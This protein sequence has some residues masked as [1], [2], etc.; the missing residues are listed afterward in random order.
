MSKKTI[1]EINNLKKFFVNKSIVNKAVDDVSF[2]LKE[3]EIVGLI[4]ES[5][6]GKTTIGRSLLRLYDDY[7]GF[8]RLDGK[9]IS[10]KKISRKTNK[11]MRKNIQMIFQDP[12]AH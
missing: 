7:N 1:L 10:G 4:G 2:D 8:V 6:S 11:F 12:M 9:L 5:G 3:G